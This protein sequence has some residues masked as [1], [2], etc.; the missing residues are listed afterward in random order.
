M[1]AILVNVTHTSNWCMISVVH[2]WRTLLFKQTNNLTL[3][4]INKTKLR[5]KMALK[6][7]KP[8]TKYQCSKD[9]NVSTA[10]QSSS[11]WM[12]HLLSVFVSFE[13]VKPLC[14]SAFYFSFLKTMKNRIVCFFRQRETIKLSRTTFPFWNPHSRSDTRKFILK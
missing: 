3:K 4:L 14:V 9:G 10:H 5:K 13:C 6:W 7:K 11:R 12:Q 2:I 8:A 1:W